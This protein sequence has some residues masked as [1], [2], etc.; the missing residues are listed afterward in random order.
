MNY[1]WLLF[2]FKGRINRAKF[3]LAMPIIVVLMLALGALIVVAG[4]PFGGPHSLS[5][6]PDDI[7]STLDTKS[8][9]ALSTTDF[10]RVAPKA[11]GTLLF[12]WLFV[13]TS[14][15]RLH[16]RDKSAWWMI[17]FFVGPGIFDQFAD[18]LG[19]SNAMLLGIVS[20]A[21]TSW[22]FIELCFLKGRNGT[23]RFGADPLAPV[24]TRPGTR[25][26]W[27]QQSELEIVPHSAG[28]SPG[29]HVM[30]GHA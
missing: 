22:Y 27:D 18:R 21:L 30:R 17:P 12:L 6:D 13:A 19:D 4:S 8:Y 10:F 25:S 23:N 20:V 29:P 7:F 26:S 3:W 1:V 28:P 5:F 2:G 16:D 11:V 15:K 24:D 9:R 14:I